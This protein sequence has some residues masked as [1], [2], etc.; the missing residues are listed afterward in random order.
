MN[1]PLQF[2]LEDCVFISDTHF[3]HAN[4]IKYCDRPFEFPDTSK[5][6]EL[7]LS[8]LQQADA[9]GKT[10]FHMGDFVFNPKHLL[11][12]KWRPTGNHYIIL[13]NHDKYADVDGKYRKLY[14][15]FF[16]TIVGYSYKWRENV[17]YIELDE[18][19][20]I[21]SHEPQRFLGS[22]EYNIYGHHHNNMIRQTDRFKDEYDWLFGSSI[23]FNAG[24]ELTNY[25]PISYND[26]IQIP[27]P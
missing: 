4:I 23:H 3:G 25:K 14:R 18:H 7:M 13:G 9:E 12:S 19:K 27:R 11:E 20:I 17:L 2:R 8:G 5:M 6:D 24:V 26:L 10:I 1:K 21:L 22:A 16:S 15:E